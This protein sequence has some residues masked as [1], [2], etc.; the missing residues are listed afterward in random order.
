MLQN[1]HPVISQTQKDTIVKRNYEE[2]E[3]HNKTHIDYECGILKI[4]KLKSKPRKLSV[5]AQLENS[6]AKQPLKDGGGSRKHQKQRQHHGA[7]AAREPLFEKLRAP[8]SRCQSRLNAS[9][10]ENRNV[11][12][13]RGTT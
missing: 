10:Y 11:T 13:M 5:Q 1:V 3:K 2:N 8:I 6:T 12:T 7:A 4:E 9:K